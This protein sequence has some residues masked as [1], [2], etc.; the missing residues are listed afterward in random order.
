LNKLNVQFA[1]EIIENIE[2]YCNDELVEITNIEQNYD[3]DSVIVKMTF[4][5]PKEVVEEEEKKK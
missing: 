4:S 1:N 3:D 5:K 2:D